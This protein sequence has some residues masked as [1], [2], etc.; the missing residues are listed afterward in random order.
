MTTS[1]F[2]VKD[3]DYNLQ[4]CQEVLLKVHFD[5]TMWQSKDFS[6]KLFHFP[7]HPPNLIFVEFSQNFGIITNKITTP[8]VE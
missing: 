5:L 6:V 4:N 8:P 2:S 7:I 3:I 1:K